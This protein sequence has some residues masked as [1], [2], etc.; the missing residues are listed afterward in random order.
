MADFKTHLAGGALSGLG[1]SLFGFYNFHIGILQAFSVFI[2]GTVGGVLPDLD[3]DTGKPL[4][5]LFGIMSVLVPSLLL[6]RMPDHGI[7]SPEFLVTY[8]VCGYFVINNMVCGLI[9]KLTVHRGIMHSIPFSVLSAELAYLLFI[10]SGR[11]FAA[12]VGISV[13]VGCAVHLLLDE[14]CSL[15][16]KSGWKPRVKNS[17]GS[18]L[19]IKSDNGFVTFLVYCIVA[20][21]AAVIY[22][23]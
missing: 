1:V 2:M 14:W 5:I 20:A 7:L 15:S 18:A 4:S 3:S 17:A 10:S 6:I 13:F 19:K 23:I 9:K 22:P 21:L 8:F 12:I 16:F 11:R